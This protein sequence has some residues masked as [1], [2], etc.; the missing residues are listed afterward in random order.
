MKKEFPLMLIAAGVATG[1]IS[2]PFHGIFQTMLVTACT[3]G[4]AMYARQ[5]ALNE[6]SIT[7]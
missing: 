3:I 5:S 2:I 7:R 6:K 4:T 1:V